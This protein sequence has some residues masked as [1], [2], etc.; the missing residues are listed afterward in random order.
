MLS[1]CEIQRILRLLISLEL[2]DCLFSQ[3]SNGYFYKTRPEN[4]ILGFVN[5]VGFSASVELI[6]LTTPDIQI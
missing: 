6:K 2:Y 1:I 4:K 3:K 5:N